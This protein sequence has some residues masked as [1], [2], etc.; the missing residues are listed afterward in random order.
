VFPRGCLCRTARSLCKLLP[1]SRMSHYT[2]DED[3][4]VFLSITETESPIQN[5][6]D[7]LEGRGITQ[8]PRT[9]DN[10]RNALK[11]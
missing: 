6:H 8:Q 3:I 4:L 10:R 11:T 9:V 2:I 7:V 1:A 5:R